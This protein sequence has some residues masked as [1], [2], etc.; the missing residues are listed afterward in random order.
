MNPRRLLPVVALLALGACAYYNGLYNAKDFARRAERAEQD[1]RTFDAQS[2]WAQAAVRAETVLVHHPHSRWT[3]EARWLDGKALERTGN[4]TAAVAPLER[5]LREA[6]DPRRADDA[7]LRLA[8]C[9]EKLGDVDAAGLAVERLIDAPDPRIRSEAR[10]RAGTTY[11]R[12]GRSAEAVRTLRSS[13]HP[14]ARGEL[15]AALADD[16]DVVGAVALADSLLAEADSLAP[17][18]AIIAAVERRDPGAGSAL[19]DRALTVL[20]FPHDSAATWLTTDALHWLATDP[21]RAHQRLDAAHRAGPN[22]EP[23]LGAL[24]TSLRLRL[25]DATDATILDT[26][27]DRLDD[28][29]NSGGPNYF[30]A[31]ALADAVAGVRSQLDSIV[32]TAPRGDMR[33]FLVGESLRDTLGA[34]RL[35]AMIWRRVLSDFPASPYLPKTLIALAAAG[36]APADSVQLVLDQRFATSPYVHAL[37]GIADPAFRTLEDSLGRYAVALASSAGSR[38]AGPQGPR[39]PAGRRGIPDQ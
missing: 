14:R 10:W 39:P 33:G 5:T 7:A 37:H 13:G 21:A 23:G 29:P 35:A 26:I 20:R 31:L 1:G 18:G 17:W 27:S 11:R 19:L 34:P 16:G 8:A 15:A 32:P 3:E 6:K 30:R 2:N 22:G 36:G 24:L 12:S 28:I 38:R 25:A 4:C 9:R